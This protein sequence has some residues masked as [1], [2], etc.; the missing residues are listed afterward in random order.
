VLVSMAPASVTLQQQRVHRLPA[1]WTVGLMTAFLG[2]T[3]FV[4]VNVPE[5]YMVSL[6]RRK[7]RQLVSMAQHLARRCQSGQALGNL[8]AAANQRARHGTDCF[9][10]PRVQQPWKPLSSVIRALASFVSVH[11]G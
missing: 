10:T 3:S 4:A 2:V 9:Y 11:A 1:S 6:Y 7:I 5:S 8:S